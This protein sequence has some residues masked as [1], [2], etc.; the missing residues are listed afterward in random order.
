M[1]IEEEEIIIAKQATR[2]GWKDFTLNLLF[3][4]IMIASFVVF[5]IVYSLKK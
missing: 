1:K 3:S 5:P 2:F 4:L